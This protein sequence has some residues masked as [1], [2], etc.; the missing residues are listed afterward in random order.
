MADSEHDTNL[1]PA[2]ARARV[3]NLLLSRLRAAGY[4]KPRG[5]AQGDFD[6]GQVALADRLAYLTP[7]NLETL[8]EAIVDT[9]PLPNWP[10]ERWV[11]DLARSLQAPPVKA[12]RLL[13]SWL[14][15]VEGP[16]AVMRGD[17]LM[18]YRYLRD[19]HVPPTHWDR[20]KIA[21]EA[22]AEDH[23]MLIWRERMARGVITEAD[24]AEMLR[25][26]ADLAEALALV[27]AGNAARAEKGAAA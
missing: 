14:A 11:L 13:S 1:T 2:A 16:K 25:H 8:A 4:R 20:R 26:E 10:P 27:D 21:D 3:E 19:R 6:L 22:K 5:L 24:R 7:D 17:L 23:R 9:A 18:L 12:S 15:S